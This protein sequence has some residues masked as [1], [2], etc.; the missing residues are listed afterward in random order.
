MNDTEIECLIEKVIA[1]FGDKLPNPDH[2]PQTFMYYVKLYRYQT[3][4]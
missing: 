1:E 4:A 2:F 3:S